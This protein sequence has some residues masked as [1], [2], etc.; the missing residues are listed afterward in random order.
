VGGGG[1]GLGLLALAFLSGI[2]LQ[3]PVFAASIGG[4][5]LVG[6]GFLFGWP[7]LSRR[8]ELDA[9]R[10]GAALAGSTE[11]LEEMFPVDADLPRED[12]LTELLYPYPHPAD[13]LAALRE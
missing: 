11:P 1:V 8:L 2:R 10:R 3:W 5:L 7:T 12:L 4:F 6:V 9:D 13:R